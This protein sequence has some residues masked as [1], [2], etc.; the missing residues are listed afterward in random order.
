MTRLLGLAVVGFA[1]RDQRDGLNAE[2]LLETS[3]GYDSTFGLSINDRPGSHSHIFFVG[4]ASL[5]AGTD[6]NPPRAQGV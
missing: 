6:Q 4:K 5:D 2:V 3:G 1:H